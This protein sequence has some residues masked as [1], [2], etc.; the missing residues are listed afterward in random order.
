MLEIG[1]VVKAHGLG[2]ETVVALVTNVEDRLRAGSSFVVSAPAGGDRRRTLVVE[3]ARAFQHRYLVR[4]EGIASR[5]A[6]EALHGWRLLAE[7]SD[8]P[9]ALF[10]HELIGSEVFDVGGTSYGLVAAVEANPASDLLVG[11]AGW[12]VPLR[13]VVEHKDGRLVVDG[14]L[15]LF[16]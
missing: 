12:L 14:P 5:E 15:G 13:F 10:V 9:D 7:P 6:A 11:E 16:E 8:D 2:G 1:T 4:F 3:T